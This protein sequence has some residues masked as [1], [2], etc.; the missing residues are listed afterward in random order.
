MPKKEQNLTITKMSSVY[1]VERQYGDG[2]TAHVQ[3]IVKRNGKINI[4]PNDP[5]RP[6]QTEFGFIDSDPALALAISDC[7][8]TAYGLSQEEK[9]TVKG[10]AVPEIPGKN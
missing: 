10:S 8:T 1:N 2:K 4:L 7:I 3:V 5:K 6:H 9:F